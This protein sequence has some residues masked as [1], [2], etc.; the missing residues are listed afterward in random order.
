MSRPRVRRSARPLRR[1]EGTRRAPRSRH[2]EARPRAT[3]IRRPE[4]GC[5]KT[6]IRDL[7]TL[8]WFFSPPIRENRRFSENVARVWRENVPQ[9][10][11]S[12]RVLWNEETPTREGRLAGSVDQPTNTRV[13]IKNV[14]SDHAHTLR[15]SSHA[16]RLASRPPPARGGVRRSHPRPPA[17]KLAVAGAASLSLLAGAVPD[18]LATTSPA[19]DASALYQKVEPQRASKSRRRH[20]GGGAQEQEAGARRRR[21]SRRRPS[22]PPRRPPPRRRPRRRPR[23]GQRRVRRR[24]RGGR[25]ARRRL[26]RERL[27]RGRQRVFGILRRGLRRGRRRRRG[28]HA[29]G[30]RGVGAGVDRRL[31]LRQVGRRRRGHARGTGRGRAEVDRRVEE[32]PVRDTRAYATASRASARKRRYLRT[33]D[34]YIRYLHKNAPSATTSR[35]RVPSLPRERPRFYAPTTSGSRSRR[36]P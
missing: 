28:R 27:A 22:P 34:I 7:A 12:P 3:S 15:T 32:G 23:K 4:R 13:L 6:N 30:A 18:A 21:A 14:T 36:R 35:L 1:N 2:R 31:R 25:R 9:W 33:A 5:C 11:P 17:L 16:R 24:A 8:A 29:R 19:L 26:R 10:E 20:R